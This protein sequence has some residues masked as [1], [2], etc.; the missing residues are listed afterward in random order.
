[1][2]KHRCYNTIKTALKERWSWRCGLD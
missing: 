2:A 1:M